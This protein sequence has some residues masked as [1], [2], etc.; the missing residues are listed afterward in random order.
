MSTAPDDTF[1]I[2][3]RVREGSVWV[4]RTGRRE[5][6]GRTANGVEIPIGQ[7]EGRVTPGELLKL[8]LIGCAG[9]SSDFTISRRLGED[10][11]MR[12]YAH[13]VS[14]E[15]T[16]RYETID[17]QIQLDL[18]E[19]SGDEAEQLRRLIRSAIGVGCTVERTLAEPPE[20]GHQIDHAPASRRLA[21]AADEVP[22]A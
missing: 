3:S 9:M 22:Q 14:D 19:V 16:N 17:E 11:P 21:T 1:P 4:D 2:P 12:I 8:A 15:R 7:G 18:S 6:T 13:G 10:F 20:I 5:L